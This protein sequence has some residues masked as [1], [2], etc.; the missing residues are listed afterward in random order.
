MQTKSEKASRID[1]GTVS[2]SGLRMGVV[3]YGYWGPNI[4]RNFSTVDGATV[5]A[6]SDLRDDSLKKAEKNHRGV[7]TTKNADE[8]IGATDIDAVAVITPV[9]THFELAKE[10]PRGRQAC[11]RREALHLHRRPRPRS[12]SS[13]P[14]R[15]ISRS[16]WTTPFSSPGAVRKIKQLV[17]DG[18]LGRPLLLRF[19]AG[20]PGPFPARRERDLGPGAARSVHHGLPASGESRPRCRHG[21]GPLQRAWRTWPTSPSTS[22]TT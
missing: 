18:T 2:A 14:T 10:G 9:F 3:G 8:L 16:W 4:V 5:V 22:P 15:R 19:H 11:L 12:S 7:R 1:K 17:D 21:T 20:Q 13:S 6:V